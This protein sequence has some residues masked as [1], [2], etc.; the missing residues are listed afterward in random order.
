VVKLIKALGFS[1]IFL[2]A[3]A[4]SAATVTIDIYAGEALLS[5][6][7]SGSVTYTDTSG[8]ATCPFGSICAATF[9]ETDTVTLTAVPTTG[10]LFG[11]W[12][13]QDAAIVPQGPCHL[14]TSLTCTF[15]ASDLITQNTSSIGAVFV[16]DPYP[17]VAPTSVTNRDYIVSPGITSTTF[18]LFADD[19][20]AT[21]SVAQQPE[22]GSVVF[23]PIY[24]GKFTYTNSTGLYQNISFDFSVTSGSGV[25]ALST[26][27]TA[28]FTIN[29]F[30]TDGDGVV[31][32][33]DQCPATRS[34]ATVNVFGCPLVNL[35]VNLVA[36]PSGQA[37]SDYGLIDM[38]PNGVSCIEG[39]CQP[40]ADYYEGQTATLSTYFLPERLLLSEW[41]N[42][43][44][45]E[46]VNTGDSC[47]FTVPPADVDG[48]VVLQADFVEN[49][50]YV[51]QAPSV[52]PLA[53][54]AEAGAE[55]VQTLFATDLEN[56]PLTYSLGE[57]TNALGE[58]S[59]DSVGAVTFTP[60]DASSSG[61]WETTVTVSDGRQ[62][63][64]VP[65]L[66]IVNPLGATLPSGAVGSFISYSADSNGAASSQFPSLIAADSGAVTYSVYIIDTEVS[67][68]ISDVAT[69]AFQFQANLGYTGDIGFIVEVTDSSGVSTA[70]PASVFV[71]QS[72]GPA[73][74]SVCPSFA[75]PLETDVT[76][77]SQCLLPNTV[78]QDLTLTSDISWVLYDPVIVGNGYKEIDLE[79]LVVEYGVTGTLQ[80]VTLTIEAGTRIL[81]LNETAALFI[82]RGSST[83][84]VGTTTSPIIFESADLGQ[85]G[86]G[87]WLGVFIQGRGIHRSCADST[88]ACN[89]PSITGFGQ[90][91]GTISTDSS[92]A[93]SYV[94]IA[95]AGSGFDSQEASMGALTLESVG[96]GT[97]I[98][99]VHVVGSAGRGMRVIGGDVDMA[100]LKLD[101]TLGASMSF[102][103]GYQGD[104]QY[105]WAALDE[106]VGD[107]VLIS[108]L[109]PV[110]RSPPPERFT[111]PLISNATLLVS[112]NSSSAIRIDGHGGLY[113]FNSAMGIP[114][115]RS[116]GFSFYSYT[117]CILIDAEAADFVG[118]ASLSTVFIDWEKNILQCARRSADFP[119]APQGVEATDST[120]ATT[121]T[122]SVKQRITQLGLAE[123]GA[124]INSITFDPSTAF[125]TSTVGSRDINTQLLAPV[126]FAG[127][128]DPSLGVPWW[129]GWAVSGLPGDE[130]ADGVFDSDDDFANDPAASRDTDGDG[131]PDDW[132]SGYSAADSTTG[133]VLDDDDDNDGLV[134]AL[135]A[136]P[137][138]ATNPEGSCPSWATTVSTG[139]CA[140]P[141]Q[142]IKDRYLTASVIWTVDGP[143]RVGNGDLPIIDVDT[144]QNNFEPEA[145]LRPTLTIEAGSEIQF[146]NFGDTLLVTRGAKINAQGSDVA[147]IVFTGTGGNALVV[148]G[149]APTGSCAGADG[150]CNNTS[151]A[152]GLYGGVDG[153]DNSGILNYVILEQLIDGRS[154][155][156][157]PMLAL[158]GV[159]DATTIDHIVVD[160]ASDRGVFLAG[161]TVHISHLGVTGAYGDSLAWTDGFQGSM[162]FVVLDM[163][164]LQQG[165]GIYAESGTG[166]RFAAGLTDAQRSA[167]TISNLTIYNGSIDDWVS[168]NLQDS[169]ALIFDSVIMKGSVRLEEFESC[170]IGVEGDNLQGLGSWLV[171]DGI[172]ADCQ[173]GPGTGYFASIGNLAQSL[174]IVSAEAALDVRL[175]SLSPQ[176]LLGSPQDWI[177]RLS[178][179][180]YAADPAKFSSVS[181]LG[182]V[183]PTAGVD[184]WWL[185][186]AT[187]D[188]P[189]ADGDGI[190]DAE[191]AFPNDASEFVDSDGDGTGDVADTDDDNDGVLDTAD[192]YPYSPRF[193]IDADGDGIA[194][195][196]DLNDA[197]NTVGLASW[198]DVETAVTDFGLASCLAPLADSGLQPADIQTLECGG[199]ISSLVGL[200]LLKALEG[201]RI[202]TG[203][204]L[205]VSAL[206]QLPALKGA[207]L[208]GNAI[209]DSTI[210][211]GLTQVNTL[212]L[213]GNHLRNIAGLSALT[214]LVR[215]DLAGNYVQK[216]DA[217][218]S[219]TQLQDLRLANNDLVDASGLASLTSLRKLDVSRNQLQDLDFVGGLSSLQAIDASNNPIESVAGFATNQSPYLVKVDLG[220]TLVP[221]LA[222]Y[223]DHYATITCP[224]IVPTGL[225][226][227]EGVIE[228][229]NL[230][231]LS[232]DELG[233]FQEGSS[234]TLS[235]TFCQTDSDLDG[236]VDSLDDFVSDPVAYKDTDNDG[237]PDEFFA[238]FTSADST[239]EP[240]LVADDDDDNDGVTDV[241]DAFPTSPFES[242]DTDG[243]GIGNNSD[244][245]SD[246]ASVKYAYIPDVID[247][248]T[249][250]ALNQCVAQAMFGVSSGFSDFSTYAD[251]PGV[252]D[253]ITAPAEPDYSVYSRPLVYSDLF[254]YLVCDSVSST[255]LSLDG[256]E[257]LTYLTELSLEGNGITDLSPLSGLTAMTVLN[258][259]NNEIADIAALAELR[260]MRNLV[261]WKNRV[262]DVSP[263]ADMLLLEY[264]DLDTNNV[265][266]VSSLDQ[267]SKLTVVY[268]YS[269]QLESLNGVQGWT[270]L[271]YGWFSDNQ[272]TDISAIQGL[273]KLEEL[274]LNNNLITDLPPLTALAS[275]SY[276]DVGDNQI[277]NGEAFIGLLQL[278]DLL[279]RGNLLTDIDFVNS[280]PALSFLNAS[281]NPLGALGNLSGSPLYDLRLNKT[282]LAE[283][284]SGRLPTT[285]GKLYLDDNNIQTLDV[286][287]TN[288]LQDG[289]ASLF[290][291]A[292]GNPILCSQ[293]DFLLNTTGIT[294]IS[295]PVTCQDDLDNDGVADIFDLYPS[296]P[297]AA[298]DSD[299]DGMPDVLF[300]ASAGLTEDTDDDNDGVADSLDAFPL[301][302]TESVDTDGDGVGDNKDA[303]PNDPAVQYFKISSAL[304]AVTDPALSS[305]TAQ[306]ADKAQT[307]D[308]ITRL[309]CA[310]EITDLSGL[311]QFPYLQQVQLVTT[312]GSGVTDLSQ[313]G[314]LPDLRNLGLSGDF[315]DLS[316]LGSLSKLETLDLLFTSEGD[317]DISALGSLSNLKTLYL[318]N[319]QVSDWSP[320]AS[321]SQLESL[322]LPGAGIADLSV[323]PLASLTSLKSLNLSLNG[324]TAL[325]GVENLSMLADL[326]IDQT[327]VTDLSALSATVGLQSLS[328]AGIPATELSTLAGLSSLES[329][330]MPDVAV[331]SSS[332]FS[333]MGGLRVLNID[334]T[335]V[336]DLTGLAN[337][338][339]M[340]FLSVSGNGLSSLNGL[341]NMTF[342]EGLV[343]SNNALTTL[344]GISALSSLVFLNVS[345][346]AI[347][348]IS[349]LVGFGEEAPY[350]L[351]Y[352]FAD[353]NQISDVSILSGW[354][355]QLRFLSF[356]NNTITSLNSL[357][358]L[359]RLESLSA[360][361]NQVTSVPNLANNSFVEFGLKIALDLTANPLDCNALDSY[362]QADI[363][364]VFDPSTCVVSEVASKALVSKGVTKSAVI[365]S[366]ASA[367]VL[368]FGIKEDAS[369]RSSVTSGTDVQSAP[370][371]TISG[372]ATQAATAVMDAIPELLWIPI[373]AVRDVVR[374]W[375][376]TTSEEVGE[377][378]DETD[379]SEGAASIKLGNMVEPVILSGHIVEVRS[380]AVYSADELDLQ[381][382]ASPMETGAE[383]LTN[384]VITPVANVYE[385]SSGG[386]G[387]SPVETQ[388]QWEL[389]ARSYGVLKGD[390]DIIW[391]NSEPQELHV[392][393]A[394]R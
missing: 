243:D 308:L 45:D 101:F 371:V 351:E 242:L 1:W 93:L 284:D 255:S 109:D 157:P 103:Q 375:L 189:D 332:I 304:A 33:G 258:L 276:L 354:L 289:G 216:A 132:N 92:G 344:D 271:R 316:A 331:S 259:Y 139:T 64:I 46:G 113:L 37:I 164:E 187:S 134:D 335:G 130:D 273:T 232:C 320:L 312:T 192:A 190:T 83:N 24:P 17:L 393:R 122:S 200:N 26:T 210:L 153:N 5:S 156:S 275:L 111:S 235:N 155:G 385:T 7:V 4:A 305:C 73:G 313:L 222:N 365:V 288:Y 182:A 128:V 358:S 152:A 100:Y 246:D 277:R 278:T 15:S 44:C 16:T 370:E 359:Y 43:T 262:E 199:S 389:F 87:E 79:G 315:A 169:G 108:D 211:S 99:H 63:K 379:V 197:D 136:Y 143:T 213:G 283:V 345:N 131:M 159:G 326:K 295:V 251:L 225:D 49:P 20:L 51:N 297:A 185:F 85:D 21:F 52:S 285:L 154:A 161:G 264:L 361:N 300:T 340:E 336:P 167:P 27:Y 219:L 117:A 281:Q 120:G 299:G 257:W 96:S 265:T 118:P 249:D 69:G 287:L 174:D 263:L 179:L 125:T 170:V 165:D 378:L 301:D 123:S 145:W 6:G 11:A 357:S 162:Q 280:M 115:S 238:G 28:T 390:A 347:T 74:D 311:A 362:S 269:N 124:V 158:L 50:D 175:A 218:N 234:L 391:M 183:D 318:Q 237:L 286:L 346:N 363:A 254:T 12:Y 105:L 36:Q 228:V 57:T 10:T 291:Y 267:L 329:L 71:T 9:N 208:S 377:L 147:P 18:V 193:S 203:A 140:L 107:P 31:D 42:L 138:D 78:D 368:G 8:P 88:V 38:I 112:E 252:T 62:S 236:Y 256:I 98:D 86:Q 59:V 150:F 339:G 70:F 321:L 97:Q 23:D 241:D 302:P 356:N 279:I 89:V 181:Y 253:G 214:N 260:Q 81:A 317:R 30:D 334:R 394:V 34:G 22:V 146:A 32:S 54:V 303:D 226:C 119:T 327:A 282:R 180:T 149:L 121:W 323:L 324:F 372:S 298:T 196:I 13:A 383:A 2:W 171:F 266:S 333:A 240:A 382:S 247:S 110:F 94:V 135:D 90:V 206:A 191:D 202:V 195:L 116:S 95:E 48:N 341:Q 322:S 230:S 239:S 133:L 129:D 178:A 3:E 137:L 309:Y 142:I 384:Y 352:L 80:N 388:Y 314:V 355:N 176:A 231:Y 376:N 177:A 307:T 151:S 25:S 209:K 104:I 148:A 65:L 194:A 114:P 72:K 168:L 127:A 233:A 207:D 227:A 163:G 272:I 223:F 261:L 386:G 367:P 41:V 35:T 338:T 82:T 76:G 290:V 342:L 66:V 293:Q 172:L 220:A 205:D 160:G 173:G 387:E 212:Y 270:N 373:V 61:R 348:S 349:G 360:T 144:V 248:V 19:S 274:E 188:A 374:S 166:N 306:Q 245:V 353:N 106:G 126:N 366:T 58:L 294:A 184:P 56:D 29:D 330:H 244:L 14:S 319:A 229:A 328:M 141:N 292:S 296:D 217:L 84:A 198:L 102:E 75:Y 364:L 215:L 77:K 53:I 310:D 55:T 39:V 369:K 380:T 224:S 350:N 68:T 204:P 343:A 201:V 221:T 268:L 40:F 337:A 47:T 392:L 250:F 60:A 186:G 381:I 325:N 67:L 91:G